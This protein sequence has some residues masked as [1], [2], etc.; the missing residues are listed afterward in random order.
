MIPFFF[1][2]G[3]EFLFFL[4]S[5]SQIR[6]ADAQNLFLP[7]CRLPCQTTLPLCYP[8]FPP[9]VS[10][11]LPYPT[12]TYSSLYK[13]HHDIIHYTQATLNLAFKLYPT[14]PFSETQN[15]LSRLFTIHIKS[16]K[17]QDYLSTSSI[18][19]FLFLLLLLACHCQPVK[20]KNQLTSPKRRTTLRNF[21]LTF[22]LWVGLLN[23]GFF[24]TCSLASFVPSP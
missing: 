16:Y 17:V 7:C 12:T 21:F 8:L 4:T 11:S 23:F 9:F 10:Y 13:S 18:N 19:I 3:G 5:S 15:I 14:L 1:Y 22:F 6:S 2:F 24:L 20:K